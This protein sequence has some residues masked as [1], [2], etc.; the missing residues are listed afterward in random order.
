MRI[1][2]SFGE[3]GLVRG[4]GWKDWESLVSF[5]SQSTLQETAHG[6]GHGLNLNRRRRSKVESWEAKSGW[7]LE[8]PIIGSPEIKKADGDFSFS[9]RAE[10]AIGIAGAR[11][12]KR[13]NGG[14]EIKQKK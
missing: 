12:R 3:Q 13:C 4:R 5:P 8:L 1:T 10:M 7:Q 2:A 6:R 14:H 11:E 9:R